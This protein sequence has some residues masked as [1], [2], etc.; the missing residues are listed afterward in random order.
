MTKQ[1]LAKGLPAEEEA[2]TGYK[3]SPSLL[4]TVVFLVT[5]AQQARPPWCLV[6][7]FCFHL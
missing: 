2:T 1:R 5:T 4:N 6:I 7:H 3:F